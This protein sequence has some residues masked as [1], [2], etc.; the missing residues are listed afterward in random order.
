MT[1]RPVP[2][3]TTLGEYER[4]ETLM[5]L[6]D[7]LPDPRVE[8][9]RAYSLAEI[10]FLV[11]SAAVSGVNTLTG[12]EDLGEAKLE[13]LRTFLPYEAGVPSHDTIGRVLGMLDPDAFEELFLDWMKTTALRI[14]EVVAIDGKTLRGAIRRGDSKSLVHMV[15]AFGTAN[16]VVYGTQ[17]TNEKS[18][19]ITAVPRLLR[20]LHIRGAIVTM[21][22]MGCQSSTLDETVERG[23]NYVVAVKSNQPTLANDIDIAFDEADRKPTTN[24]ITSTAETDGPSHGRGETRRCDVIDAK[25]WISDKS[26]WTSV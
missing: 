21:D 9:T 5:A 1:R 12:I 11:L 4:V 25:R 24:L 13:W 8:R 22:A 19:E 6:F 2:A 26:K 23:G 20:L 18:N 15:T 16:G 3:P 7:A 17:K 14:D 10:L